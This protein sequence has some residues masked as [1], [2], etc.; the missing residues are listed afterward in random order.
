MI[1]G[2]LQICAGVILLQL[3]KSAKDVPDAAVFKGDLDQVRTVAEQEQ[4]ESEPK[5]DAIRGAA[6]IIRRFSVSRQKMEHEEA[7]RLYDEKMRDEME[8]IG[9]NEIVEWDGLRRRKTI[10]GESPIVPLQRRKTIHPPLGMSHFPSE[11]EE[12]ERRATDG[13]H[14]DRPGVFE[15][16]RSRASTVLAP[17][18]RNS[19]RASQANV[20]SPM[21]PVPLTEITIGAGKSTDPPTTPYSHEEAQEHIYGLPEGLRATPADRADTPRSIGRGRNRGNSFRSEAGG[22]LAPTPPPHQTSRR[23]FSFQNVFHRARSDDGASPGIVSARP[24]T[25]S[26]QDVPPPSRKGMGSRQSSKEQAN[27]LKTATEEERLGLVKGDSHAALYSQQ[28]ST[29]PTRLPSQHKSKHHYSSSSDVEIVEDYEFEHELDSPDVAYHDR[30]NDSEEDWQI[31]NKPP[32]PPMHTT[33]P[34]TAQPTTAITV[35]KPLPNI[36]S[37]GSPPLPP[38]PL[39]TSARS[40]PSGPVGLPAHPAVNVSP[41]RERGVWPVDELGE[42]GRWDQQQNQ[43]QQQQHMYQQQLHQLHSTQQ[44]QVTQQRT[45]ERNITGT[46]PNK[47]RKK[48]RREGSEASN[49]SVEERE[50]KDYEARNGRRGGD[51]AFI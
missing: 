23:Q 40:P 38:L 6:A 50:L 24:P 30:D 34:R 13:D 32:R 41:E 11:T 28:H 25:A 17:G 18:H 10:I 20:R 33:P 42:Y 45:Q 48:P 37:G 51:G 27:A 19:T 22:S 29:S 39:N 46:G 2:F 26:S 14:R 47:L 44:Q 1:M 15:T 12:E 43:Q 9:E 7:R 16:F 36:T 49:S 3:S 35:P 21:H 5:A 8:P 4:P 31:E